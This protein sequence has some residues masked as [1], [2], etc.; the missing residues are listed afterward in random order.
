MTSGASAF[1]FLG[2]CGSST[3][4]GGPHFILTTHTYM[5]INK[6]LYISDSSMLKFLSQKL[7]IKENYF[8]PSEFKPEDEIHYLQY[9]YNHLKE[10]WYGM[11]VFDLMQPPSSKVDALIEKHQL[12]WNEHLW[13]SIWW[14]N[15]QKSKV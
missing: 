1:P 5:K 7:G 9:L 10:C 4:V 3:Q 15:T 14:D 2:E 13:G 8:Y 12:E 6:D 11:Q